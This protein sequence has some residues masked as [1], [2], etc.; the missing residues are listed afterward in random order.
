MFEITDLKTPFVGP[1]SLSIAPGECVSLR[2]ASGAGK[3]LLLR[4][5]ADLDPNDGDVRYDRESRNRMPAPEWRRLVAMIPA[6]SG[7]WTDNVA[8]HFKPDPETSALLEAVGLPESLDWKV[9][10]LSTGEKQRL[11]LARALH[12]KPKVLLLDEP[13]SALDDQATERMEDIV[14]QQMDQGVA[15]LLVTHDQA[16][17]RRLGGR[18]F[19]MEHG[20]LS[21]EPE[22]VA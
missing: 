19:Q 7:W 14:R 1:V 20:R 13:T 10:R 17:A 4:A 21:E 9:N 15:I 3:S 8:D 22:A 12:N 11:A 6:E 16:Q 5:I 2:G 18:H